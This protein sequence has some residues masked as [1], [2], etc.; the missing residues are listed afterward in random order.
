MTTNPGDNVH[1]FCFLYMRITDGKFVREFPDEGFECDPDNVV[2]MSRP[3]T[4][5]KP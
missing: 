4:A 1:N 3:H 2:E 5:A